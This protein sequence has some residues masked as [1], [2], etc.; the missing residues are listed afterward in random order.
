MENVQLKP[1][2]IFCIT[3]LLL[4]AQKWKSAS[5]LFC[6][7]FCCFKC[8]QSCLMKAIVGSGYLSESKFSLTRETNVIF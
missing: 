2:G 7:V 8:M 4:D 3:S 1:K 5:V 6:C